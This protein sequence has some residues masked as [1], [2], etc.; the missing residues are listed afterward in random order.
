[1]TLGPFENPFPT[2][3]QG[4][5]EPQFASK[6]SYFEHKIKQVLRI[7]LGVIKHHWISYLISNITHVPSDKILDNLGQ[8]RGL[9][10]KTS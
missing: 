7:N 2:I 8:F 9:Y 5:L 4:E 3:T 6:D 1:M 10:I